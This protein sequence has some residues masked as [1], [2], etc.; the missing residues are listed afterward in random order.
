MLRKLYC[1]LHRAVHASFRTRH[2]LCVVN[3][4]LLQADLVVALNSLA[5]R[6]DQLAE[7]VTALTAALESLSDNKQQQQLQHT[8][9]AAI[10]WI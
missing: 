10:P 8:G 3:V 5:S 9:I 6:Q 2:E 4:V 1:S 7:A